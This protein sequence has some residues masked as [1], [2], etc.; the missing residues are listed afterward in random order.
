[1]RSDDNAVI[2]VL[3]NKPIKG[4]DVCGAKARERLRELF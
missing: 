4:K 3:L 2:K 1:M